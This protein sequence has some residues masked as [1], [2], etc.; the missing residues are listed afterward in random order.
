MSSIV[1]AESW[2]FSVTDAQFGLWVRFALDPRRG[3][4]SWWSVVA[5]AD[6]P[7]LL[8]RDET[9]ALP[10]RKTMEVR[11]QGLWADLTCHEPMQRWQVNFEGIAVALDDPREVG[12]AEL[13]HHTPVEL[14]FEWEAIEPPQP[15]AAIDGYVQRCTVH[16]EMQIGSSANVLSIDDPVV[17]LRD[18]QRHR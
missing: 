17:G 9:L 4:A 16:G 7:L 13:G 5:R 1:V 3:T 8:V 12:G 15:Y 2:S 14:E 11:G 18:E 10:T 6:Q